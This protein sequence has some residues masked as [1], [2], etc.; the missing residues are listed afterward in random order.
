M[1][2]EILVNDG[3]APA[4]ILPFTAGS[5]ITGGRFVTMGTDGEIDHSGADAHN[6]LGVALV[7]ASSGSVASVVTGKG[8][9]CN[10]WL[11]GTVDEGLLVDI[12]A[13]GVA[14]SGGTDTAIA[15]SGTAVGITLTG[16]AFGATI[17]L[18]KCLLR[19]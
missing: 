6:A 5:A 3:G 8:V 4:R 7:D 15:A 11:S 9:I 13:D 1:A 14:H 12:A 16:A 17:T 10:V 2:T 18:G 19:N